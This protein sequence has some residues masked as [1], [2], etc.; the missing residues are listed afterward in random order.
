[1]AI[2][3]YKGMEVPTNGEMPDVGSP[4]PNFTGV[5]Q[6]M[7]EVSLSELKGKRVVLNVFPN[8]DTTVCATSVRRFNK[9]AASLFNTKVV[10]L[11]KDLPFAHGRFCTTEGIDHVMTLSA[12]RNSSFE[13][14]YGMLITEGPIAGLLARGVIVI[15]EAGKILY[16]EL[17]PNIANEP[18]YEAA[19]ASL[20]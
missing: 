10:A 17:V 7:S 1:M 15:D 5:C 8:L 18:D 9:E 4:A 3:I 14:N 19:L 11:S 16:S 6:D 13:D 12:Y 20:R 2:V